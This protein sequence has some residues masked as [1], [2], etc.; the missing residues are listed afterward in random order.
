MKV[1]VSVTDSPVFSTLEH[2]FAG[3]KE[4]GADG[5]E[6]TPGI[7]SRWNYRKIKELS[8]KYELQITAV[9]QPPWSIGGIW[10]DEGFIADAAKIGVKNYVFHPP[11]TLT[12]KDEG[13]N[14]FLARLA[15]LQ[16]KYSV[17]AL[18]ENMP[19]AVR[20]KLLRKYLPY[21]SDTYE[22]EKIFKA[23]IDLDWE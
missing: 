20:P 14:K 5:V 18:L 13:M 1:S 2:H 7:K 11:S 8:V 10:F 9:H 17:N 15:E 16:K 23:T 4:A 22:L 21:P 6:I 19:W 12:F 3:L